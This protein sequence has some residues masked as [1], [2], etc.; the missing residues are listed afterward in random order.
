MFPAGHFS[1]SQP[2][3]MLWERFSLLSTRRQPAPRMR[4][5]KGGTYE[6]NVISCFLAANQPETKE[7]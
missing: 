7:G 2:G 4:R 3:S 1:G 6:A 5:E